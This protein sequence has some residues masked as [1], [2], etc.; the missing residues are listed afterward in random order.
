MATL[1]LTLTH[2]AERL[3]E[4]LTPLSEADAGNGWAL[5]VYSAAL[6]SMFDELASIFTDDDGDTPG[7]AKLFDVDTV[8]ARYLP[9]VAQFVGVTVPGDLPE[10]AQRLRVKETD[11]FKRGSPDAIRGAA[12]QYLTGTKTVFLTERH[13]SAYRLTVATLASETPN[14][15]VVRK[16][17]EAQTPAGIVVTHSVITGGDLATLRDTHSDFADVK[18]TFTDLAEVRDNP[19]KQ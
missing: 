5:A 11:G 6:A 8:P 1:P 17:V 14:A 2:T 18:T 4:A 12:R 9:W 3:Y 15:T 19:A 16:A 10:D 13:G 7:G